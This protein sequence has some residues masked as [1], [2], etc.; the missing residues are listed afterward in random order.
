MKFPDENIVIVKRMKRFY[1][2]RYTDKGKA[3]GENP[4]GALHKI[5]NKIECL[6]ID[7]FNGKNGL[8]L[9]TT[10]G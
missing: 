7:K 8:F 10:F 4:L 3:R 2:A 6:K 1:F 9:C 5:K